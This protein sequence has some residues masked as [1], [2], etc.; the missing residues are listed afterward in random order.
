VATALSGPLLSTEY[1][2][3][4]AGTSVG[5]PP[6]AVAR[7]R[8]L[9]AR[10]R[11]ALGPASPP[12]AVLSF[13]ARPLVL[14]LGWP[15]PP[16]AATTA[17]PALLAPLLAPRTEP[18]GLVAAAYGRVARPGRLAI[19]ESLAAGCRWLIVTDGH[20]LRLVDGVRAEARAFVEFDLDACA[21]DAESL[22]WLVRLAGPRAFAEADPALLRWLRESDAWGRRVC[23]ALRAGVGDALSAFTE[24]VAVAPGRARDLHACYADALVAVYRVLFLLFAEARQLVPMW[25]AAYRRGYSVEALRTRLA[26][27]R[28]PR[29][30]WA[31]LQAMARLAHAGV[32]AGDLHV[33]PFNGRLF[34]PARAPLLDHLALDDGRV[35]RALEALCFTPSGARGGRQRIAYGELGVEELGAVYENLLDLEPAAVVP[36]RDRPA[37]APPAVHLRRSASAARK[38]TGTFYTPRPLAD[39]L[40]RETLAPLV[41]AR[42]PDEILALRVLDPAMGSGAFLVAAGR[43]LAEQWEHAVVASGEA[44]AGDVTEADRAAARRI[45]ASRCLFGVDRNPMAVQLA[46]LSLWLATLSADR[47]LS[48]LDHHLIAGNSLVGATPLDVLSRPPGGR[49]RAGPLPLE[50]LFDWSAALSP[51]RARRHEIETTPDDSAEVVRRKE[52]ALADLASGGGLARWLAAC[53]LWCACWTPGGV[54]RGLYHALLDRIVSGGAPAADAVGLEGRRLEQRA[55]ALACVHW[56]LQFPEVFLDADGRP[57]AGAGFDAV[58]GN[59]P[60]EMLRADPGRAADTRDD[61]AAIVRFARDS[62]VY[63]AQ[64]RG[65]AN[66]FQL[67]VERALHLARPGGRIGLIVPSG[68][69]TDEGSE[70]LRRAL[71]LANGLD[72]I[73]VFDNRRGLFPIHRSL[74]FAAIT[75]SRHGRT[76]AIRCRFGVA[77]LPPDAR[78]GPDTVTLTPG[79]LERLSG[80]GLAVPDLPSSADMRL[81]ERLS[82]AHPRLGGARGWQVTFGRELNATEDRD[83]FRA[84]TARPGDLPVVEGR[85]LSPFQVDLAGVTRHADPARVRDRLGERA[86]VDRP[87][88]AYRDVASASNRTTLIAAILPA[89]AVSVHTVF[90]AA[91]RMAPRDQR[92]LCALLNS[93]V[94]NYLVRRRVTMHVTAAIV[95]ALPVPGPAR[96]EDWFEELDAAAGLLL[97]R[98]TAEATARA[99]ALAA[100]AYGLDEAELR[101]VLATFPLVPRAERDAVVMAFLTR[102]P[103]RSSR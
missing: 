26:A 4:A 101:H 6:P 57:G 59:P 8:S 53:D 77:E 65:H 51:V 35:A 99:Q 16:A 62:G 33:T 87:R 97:D 102:T 47:P 5:I 34:A 68:L 29:G 39:A 11:H 7:F 86:A 42:R 43:Y 79:L 48:F 27:G 46:Q 60:W 22:A 78:D 90:C 25:H 64:G 36:S 32:E 76:Q 40:V 56:P 71:V 100:V 45:I 30:T 83:C 61:G 17:G 96:D 72:S 82:L 37:A 20:V 81:V 93:F 84:G 69:L 55:R 49:R 91:A 92:V 41:E 13:A 63:A 98:R 58:V 9:R 80:P 15:G 52:A 88:L 95:A 10:C 70:P 73:T 28:T 67:F 21:E 74:R 18:V 89:G 12:S 31:A 85:H 44:T 94:A 2:R 38:S 19:A 50:A 23:G 14:W 66:Q 1:L 103:R 3:H 54:G 75:V 24:A